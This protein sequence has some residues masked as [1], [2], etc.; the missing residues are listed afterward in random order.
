LIYL[1]CGIKL[2]QKRKMSSKSPYSFVNR[3]DNLASIIPVIFFSIY[4]LF[5]SKVSSVDG[6]GFAYLIKEGEDL[7]LSHHL[8]Y[9]FF[10]FIWVRFVHYFFDLDTLWLLKVMNSLAAG[11]SLMLLEKIL[12]KRGVE[13]LKRILWVVFAGSSW[14]FMRFAT[15]NETYILPICFSL[16]GS[17]WI[18]NYLSNKKSFFLFLAGFFAAFAALVH[19]IHF[20]WWLGILVVL[21]L[22]DR[23]LKRLAIYFLPAIIVP[24]IYFCAFVFYQNN[25]FSFV[26]LIQFIFHDYQSG[27]AEFSIE[28]KNF[29]LTPISF[30]RTFVQIHGYMYNFFKENWWFI[31]S[32][33]LSIAFFIKFMIGLKSVRF[34][35]KKAKSVNVFVPFKYEYI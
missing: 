33:T 14:G 1:L 19:Q 6:F 3:Y 5:F 29:L 7:F 20:F 25:S 24:G 30:I 2:F 4:C 12:K 10:G 16:L 28:S 22:K 18:V 27:V 13:T 9:N 21:L 11:V 32:L 8:L 17:L 23:S 15:E 31:F 34:V 26:S 35:L